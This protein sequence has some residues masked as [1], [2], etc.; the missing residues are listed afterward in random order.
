LTVSKRAQLRELEKEVRELRLDKE[1]GDRLLE[2]ARL[3]TLYAMQRAVSAMGLSGGALHAVADG[4]PV[5]CGDPGRA[6]LPRPSHRVS[7]LEMLVREPA[8]DRERLRPDV[9]AGAAG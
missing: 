5:Q 3:N 6:G 4:H 1:C 9:A 2:G 7:R 8:A